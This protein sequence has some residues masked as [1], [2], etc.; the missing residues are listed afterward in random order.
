M[1]PY[2]YILAIKFQLITFT[3]GSFDVKITSYWN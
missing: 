1:Y 3:D 2:V